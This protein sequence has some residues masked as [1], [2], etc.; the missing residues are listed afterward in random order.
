MAKRADR[1][2]WGSTKVLRLVDSSNLKKDRDNFTVIVDSYNENL[3]YK[4]KDILDNALNHFELEW[5]K[6]YGKGKFI[7]DI[8]MFGIEWEEYENKHTLQDTK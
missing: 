5:V 8:K 4:P 1:N 2:G 7:N 6:N 3:I